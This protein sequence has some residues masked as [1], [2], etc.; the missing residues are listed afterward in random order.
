MSGDLFGDREL[1]Q[2][3]LRTPPR[4]E[5]PDP[6]PASLRSL[7]AV[8]LLAAAPAWLFGLPFAAAALWVIAAVATRAARNHRRLQQ[9]LR[10]AAATV[11]LSFAELTFT[12][13]FPPVVRLVFYGVLVGA[14]ILLYEWSM[15]K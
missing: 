3:R 12:V 4:R 8:A 15:P 5:W 13:A 6:E 2:I 11:F 7:A 1:E 14:V 10:V 9:T